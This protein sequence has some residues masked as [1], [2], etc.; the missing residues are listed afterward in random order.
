MPIAVIPISSRLE[1]RAKV[2]AD[3]LLRI[4]RVYPEL[5]EAN[6]HAKIWSAW[7][8]SLAEMM[9]ELGNEAVQ[10]FGRDKESRVTRTDLLGFTGMDAKFKRVFPWY[11]LFAND[12]VIQR[13]LVLLRQSEIA[14][15]LEGAA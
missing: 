14:W 2:P 5:L 7:F 1:P 8:A 6:P 11:V 12:K 9:G 10:I 15:R 13:A 4:A 3:V